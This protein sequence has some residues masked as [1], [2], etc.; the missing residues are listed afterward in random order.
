MYIV[1][2]YPSFSEVGIKTIENK[3]G[4]VRS[5]NGTVSL[6]CDEEEKSSIF[7]YSAINY[8]I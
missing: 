2:T 3:N 1:G 5:D 8:I 7:I 4:Y 6:S